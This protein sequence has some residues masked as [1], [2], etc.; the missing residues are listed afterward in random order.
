VFL[1]KNQC[2]T[3]L[4][5]SGLR[6]LRGLRRMVPSWHWPVRT[7]EA[8]TVHLTARKVVGI[9]S[10]LGGLTERKDDPSK[11]IGRKWDAALS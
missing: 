3:I 1:L 9:E 7:Q 4:L 8:G 10:A 6:P 5:S 11:D 2:Q